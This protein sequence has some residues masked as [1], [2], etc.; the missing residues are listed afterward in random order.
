MGLLGTYIN[1]TSASTTELMATVGNLFTDLWLLVVLV[2]G[3]PFG[4]YFI[5]KIIS[6][7]PKR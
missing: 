2:A 3:I 4:I 5:R 6:L 1:L 7:A